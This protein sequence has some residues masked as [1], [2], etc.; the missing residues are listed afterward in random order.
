[1]FKRRK[2]RS[3]L[4]KL[5]EVLWP[6]MGWRRMGHYLHL[7]MIRLNASPHQIA[8]GISFGASISFV[9]LPGTHIITA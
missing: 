5:R 1:M 3:I 4:G 2:R 8:L 6:K 7:R 9:P